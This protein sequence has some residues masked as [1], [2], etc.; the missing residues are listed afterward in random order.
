MAIFPN[1]EYIFFNLQDVSSEDMTTAHNIIQSNAN[2]VRVLFS[3][4]GVLPRQ[5]SV[6]GTISPSG[7]PLA[8]DV[9]QFTIRF[10]PGSGNAQIDIG[11]DADQSVVPQIVGGM[12]IDTSGHMIAIETN[13]VWQPTSVVIGGVTVYQRTGNLQIPLTSLTADNFVFISYWQENVN[14]PAEVQVAP[15]STTFYPLYVDSYQIRV[16]TTNIPTAGEIFLGRVNATN[17]LIDTSARIQSLILGQNV[18]V[19]IAVPNGSSGNTSA[20]TPANYTNSNMRVSLQDHCNALGTGIVSPTNPHGYS[21][22]DITG[23][24]TE[25]LN[26]LYQSEVMSNGIVDE[27][28]SN[29]FPP[30][31]STALSPAIVNSAFNVGS[32]LYDARVELT[33]LSQPGAG[34]NQVAYVAGQ[35]FTQAGPL[36]STITGLSTNNAF[37][38]FASGGVS[39]Q[40]TGTY[41]VYVQPSSASGTLVAG[42]VLAGAT[43]AANQMPICQVYW[44]A[45][46]SS[47]SK[48]QYNIL[49]IPVDLR[50]FGLVD[51]EQFATAVTS[52]PNVGSLSAQTRSNLCA[53]SNFSIAAAGVP[54]NWSLW[55]PSPGTATITQTTDTQASE[56]LGANSVGAFTPLPISNSAFN[57]WLKSLIETDGTSGLLKPN[58]QYTVTAYFKTSSANLLNISVDITNF[59]GVSY[60]TGAVDLL[61]TRDSTNWYRVSAVLKMG[62]TFNPADTTAKYLAFNFANDFGPISATPPVTLIANVSLVEGN[63]T[64]GYENGRFVPSGGNVFFD[65]LSVCPP[66]FQLNTNLQGRMPMGANGAGLVVGAAPGSAATNTTIDSHDH[67]VD[68]TQSSGGASGGAY[69]IPNYGVFT[70]SSN[71]ANVPAYVGI[72]C[73]AL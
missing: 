17:N 32:V 59:A 71:S 45:S 29:N 44:D 30:S 48:S 49:T 8:F 35:R 26:T 50:D 61:P 18:E 73:R 23:G 72:W 2:L 43:L 63:W 39:P 31:S 56:Q 36:T 33:Q 1:E 70:T 68:I 57:V 64:E 34:S 6:A 46:T 22:S 41:V 3:N 40:V 4:P 10:T 9:R 65:T 21:I 38:P 16:S 28:L 19:F 25:P 67:T 47:L 14:S 62:S 20:L 13:T 37:V 55:A 11:Y 42:I 5:S 7:V 53:N 54:L 51:I 60:T 58:K 15:G 12:A 52:D 66:G 69:G 27:S 24:G